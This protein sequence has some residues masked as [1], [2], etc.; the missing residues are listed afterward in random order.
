[1]ENL[2]RT[3]AKDSLAINF[4][5]TTGMLSMEGA[6]YPENP[7]D[8]FDPL[9]AWVEQYCAEHGRTL[10]LNAK[11]N[12]LNTSSAKCLLDFFGR[13]EDFHAAGGV[14]KVNWYYEEDDEDM[15]ETGLELCEDLRLPYELIAY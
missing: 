4:D 1:M 12:Y 14:V 5:A 10:T 3:R 11:I 2:N 13:L 8:F 6:S 7:L 9:Y 15:Q